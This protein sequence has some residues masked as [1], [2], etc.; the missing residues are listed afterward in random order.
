MLHP[1][2]SATSLM[3]V[4][5]YV[6]LLQIFDSFAAVLPSTLDAGFAANNRLLGVRIGSF[7]PAVLD[8]RL[9]SAL[10]AQY[11]CSLLESIRTAVEAAL[12]VDGGGEGSV[13][14]PMHA[15]VHGPTLVEARAS[16]AALRERI[17]AG[18]N[19][20]LPGPLIV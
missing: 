11:V 20:L 9:A 7:C 16:E 5:C 4:S 12:L 15:A 3:V 10:V 14:V 13:M 1:L 2:D 18:M 19:L 6:R 17:A 8:K